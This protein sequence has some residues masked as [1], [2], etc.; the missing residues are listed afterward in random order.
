M[1]SLSERPA[2]RHRRRAGVRCLCG[3]VLL[4]LATAAG[5][6]DAVRPRCAQVANAITA[7]SGFLAATV[8][9]SGRMVYRQYVDARVTGPRYNLLRHAGALYALGDAR[10]HAP[11]FLAPAVGPAV[12]RGARWLRRCCVFKVPGFD[13]AA[14]AWSTPVRGPRGCAEA[15][16]GGA[17]LALLAYTEA[18]EVQPG[19]VPAAELSGL[20]RFL[21]YLQRDDG[22]FHSKFRLCHGGR[23]DSW[24][25]LYYPGEA[26]L[27]LMRFAAQD[28]QPQWSV[29]AIA[30]LDYL[31]RTRASWAT[32][33]IPADHW[34]LLATA[35]LF[36]ST[37]ARSLD[38]SRRA[39][40]LR[41]AQQVTRAILATP[42]V[43]TLHS[44]ARGS[45]GHDGRTTPT[46][47]RLEALLAA[48]RLWQRAAPGQLLDARL[49]TVI[50]EGVDFL[51]RAQRRTAPAQGAVPRAV[52]TAT[53]R[54]EELRIDY[55]Q[56]ALSAFVAYR[57][58]VLDCR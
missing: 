40:L 31:A 15:K 2:Q 47:T 17:A 29:A 7:A 18:N 33:E 19:A 20:A 27:A 12:L 46:A 51:L 41:H 32:R 52:L 4:A 56:H 10:A 6:M 42:R 23:D 25:S 5:A 30:A 37:A 45:F 1:Q 22:S 53:R 13:V 50:A 34:A 55:T 11:A 43:T 21:I 16:L 36:E 57:R 39:R 24:N 8:L 48:R 35:A 28:A 26:A 38:A 14:A 58:E 44:P 54:A 3:S 9:P 49:D